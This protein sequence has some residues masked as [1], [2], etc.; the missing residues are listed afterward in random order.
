M[1]ATG[2]REKLQ[3]LLLDR[4]KLSR[5]SALLQDGRGDLGHH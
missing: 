5:V 3:A 1:R 2:C 4:K